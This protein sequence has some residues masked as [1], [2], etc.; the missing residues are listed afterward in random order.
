MPNTI[1]NHIKRSRC[2]LGALV[3][4]AVMDMPIKVRNRFAIQVLEVGSLAAVDVQAVAELVG[5]P[6]PLEP[7][8]CLMRVA[9]RMI[10]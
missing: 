4:K 3:P 2:P 9:G 8:R 7:K 10:G 5:V 1:S 6:E